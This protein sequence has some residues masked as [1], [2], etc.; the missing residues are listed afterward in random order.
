M[1]KPDGE[2]LG[3]LRINDLSALGVHSG[4]VAIPCYT[5]VI[6]IEQTGISS[7]YLTYNLNS[8]L[9]AREKRKWENILIV[10]FLCPHETLLGKQQPF[11]YFNFLRD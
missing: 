5:I 4:K 9:P 6:A 10:L 1:P 8:I 7:L 3:Y 11:S 2:L